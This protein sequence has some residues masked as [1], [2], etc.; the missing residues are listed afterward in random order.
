MKFKLNV[1]PVYPLVSLL[2]RA[3]GDVLAAVRGGHL[4]AVVLAQNAAVQRFDLE[5]RRGQVNGMH[6]G[7]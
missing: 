2:G 5:V 1:S 7:R 3:A 4:E 6:A